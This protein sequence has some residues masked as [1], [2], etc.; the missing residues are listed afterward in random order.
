MTGSRK[1]E[2][3]AKMIK[4]LLQALCLLGINIRM[5]IRPITKVSFT[6][7]LKLKSWCSTEQ[8]RPIKLLLLLLKEI[9]NFFTRVEFNCMT[10]MQRAHL[11]C[12]SFYNRHIHVGRWL[13]R[14]SRGWRV[15]PFPLSIPECYYYSVNQ[16]T[17]PGVLHRVNPLTT[18]SVA[19][20]VTD[21]PQSHTL[22]AHK[23][24]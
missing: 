6:E 21:R 1:Q 15:D 19:K 8:V 5:N 22:N 13:S 18:R 7:L 12:F 10:V 17:F 20:H 4:I 16:T 23:N 3:I 14:P 24:T 2:K 9:L 11:F